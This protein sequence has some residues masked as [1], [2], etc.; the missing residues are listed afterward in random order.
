MLT[1]ILIVDDQRTYTGN[2]LSQSLVAQLNFV[3][4][5]DT[6]EGW[7][8]YVKNSLT[9]KTDIKFPLDHLKAHLTLIEDMGF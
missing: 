5:T 6:S 1:N 2:D 4:V 8:W 9:G 3:I 7:F